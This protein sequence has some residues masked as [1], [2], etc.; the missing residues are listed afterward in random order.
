MKSIIIG[1]GKSTSERM[2]KMYVRY[3]PLE[4]D[5]KNLIYS[6]SITPK[7]RIKVINRLRV[8]NIFGTLWS[9]TG[10]V[11][12]LL[13]TLSSFLI[14]IYLSTIGI[15]LNLSENL[16][17]AKINPFL[18]YAPYFIYFSLIMV[19]LYY[20]IVTITPILLHKIVT[21]LP[22]KQY[23]E[24]SLSKLNQSDILSFISYK[25]WL[26]CNEFTKGVIVPK[27]YQELFNGN[28][29]FDR[30]AYQKLSLKPSKKDSNS[31]SP[32]LKSTNDLKKQINYF[33][34]YFYDEVQKCTELRNLS[35]SKLGILQRE[36]CHHI[37]KFSP[38]IFELRIN[39]LITNVETISYIL[40]LDN[41]A[42]EEYMFVI[43][44]CMKEII[45]IVKD[46][47]EVRMRALGQLVV[48]N[49]IHECLINLSSTISTS[50][51]LKI[52]TRGLA[53][54]I[55]KLGSIDEDNNKVFLEV[56]SLLH[57]S[58]AHYG[59]D[60]LISLEN[61]YRSNFSPKDKRYRVPEIIYDIM[62][63]KEKLN[64]I[65]DEKDYLIKIRA[66]LLSNYR[67]AMIDLV[68]NFKREIRKVKNEDNGN[69]FI[70]VFGY[71]RMVRNVLK[72]SVNELK[73]KKVKIFVMKENDIEMLDTR[74][75]RFEL[76]DEKPSK[77][78][79]SSFTSSDLFFYNLLEV[80]DKLIMLAGAEAYSKS[81][82]RLLHTNNYQN[83]IESLIAKL[84]PEKRKPFP[85]VWVVGGEY[86]IYDT[87]PS[88]DSLFGNEFFSDHYDKSDFYDFTDLVEAKRFKLITNKK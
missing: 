9:N 27:C 11:I 65:L 46:I 19:F 30:R 21:S 80:S 39:T 14:T 37:L 47:R 72:A 7:E 17:L 74:M 4:K 53:S 68:L 45:R 87:F 73:A 81:T 22:P 77:N 1:L 3:F 10:A 15:I 26:L 6:L 49:D 16:E 70:L 20:L 24:I 5:I 29:A 85:N 41:K 78:Y 54:L 71:S 8:H 40:E 38:P 83:R 18:S 67:V 57:R 13:L 51:S 62:H 58:K 55:A 66:D 82:N 35:V 34:A 84:T 69:I 63:K 33:K 61:F 36:F 12:G 48:F 32:L 42:T 43:E 28:G 50:Q 25:M 44:D 64:N 2:I 79:R 23:A 59:I 52:F 56:K 31:I 75:F 76:N 88:E 86:K 60:L